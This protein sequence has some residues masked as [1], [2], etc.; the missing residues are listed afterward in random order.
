[1]VLLLQLLQFF[2]HDSKLYYSTILQAGPPFL[3]SAYSP[4]AQVIQENNDLVCE[5]PRPFPTSPPVSKPLNMA[6]AAETKAIVAQFDYTDEDVNKGVKEF[7][8]QMGQYELSHVR[9][10]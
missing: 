3:R 7:L 8:R 1:M 6:L 5:I 4:P 2:L 10:A 9:G